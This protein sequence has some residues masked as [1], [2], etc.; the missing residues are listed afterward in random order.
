MKEIEEKSGYLP[1]E[2]LKLQFPVE[3]LTQDQTL[4]KRIPAA[5]KSAELIFKSFKNFGSYNNWSIGKGNW[6]AV[7][8]IP[9][10]DVLIV[11]TMITEFG[12]NGARDLTYGYKYFL[13][14]SNG[15]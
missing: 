4:Y 6:D 9:N 7:A 8:F 13:H 3:Q 1:I 11:G 5:L 14:D 2:K 12:S 10:K 15:N